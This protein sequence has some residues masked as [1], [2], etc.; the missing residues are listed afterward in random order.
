MA[1]TWATE[2]AQWKST[3]EVKPN[4]LK[5]SLQGKH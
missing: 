4:V 1:E 5:G 3:I 2:A